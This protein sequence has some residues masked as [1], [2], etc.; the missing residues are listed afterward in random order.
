MILKICQIP[1]IFGQIQVCFCGNVSQQAAEVSVRNRRPSYS[2]RR[3]TVAYWD[4]GVRRSVRTHVFISVT[5]ASTIGSHSQ[6]L[7]DPSLTS[8]QEATSPNYYQPVFGF[9]P[10]LIC[11]FACVSVCVYMCLREKERQREGHQGQ[12]TLTCSRKA[13]FSGCVVTWGR[14]WSPLS[15]SRSLEHFNN[16]STPPPLLPP[17]LTLLP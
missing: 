17:F 6:K 2:P 10:I 13:G 11:D 7:L 1:F 8:D 9:L 15:I 5:L 16:T 14:I 12:P 4:A 3:R